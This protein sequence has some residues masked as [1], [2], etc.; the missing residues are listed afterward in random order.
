MT[1][2]FEQIVFDKIVENSTILYNELESKFGKISKTGLIT[3]L[4]FWP[5]LH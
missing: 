3:T 1:N 4:S 5:Q 2:K